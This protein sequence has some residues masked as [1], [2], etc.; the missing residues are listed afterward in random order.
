MGSVSNDGERPDRAM[1]MRRREAK[2][3]RALRQTA[4]PLENDK[5]V[6]GSPW[7]SRAFSVAMVLHDRGVFSDW[8]EFR[9]RLIA[10]IADWERRNQGEV[11]GWSYYERWLAALEKLVVEKGILS[12]QEIDARAGECAKDK[13]HAA[14]SHRS[15]E[16]GT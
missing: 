12:R 15:S 16:G 4:L 8:E 9:S 13:G 10:E 6:F 3:L 14:R 5:P 1:E 2:I 7:E 11:E